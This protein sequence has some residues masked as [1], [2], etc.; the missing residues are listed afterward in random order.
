MSNTTPTNLPPIGVHSN[1]CA[2][3][4]DHA[5]DCDCALAPLYLKAKID[6]LT[7]KA[8]GLAIQV[9]ASAAK[10]ERLQ[11]AVD[12]PIPMILTCPACGARHIDVG[13]FATRRH[14]THACQDCGMVWRPAIVATC[15]VQFLPGFKNDP[16]AA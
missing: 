2:K 15:G 11:T 1:T 3:A 10:L 7:E 14:H 4:H 5:K 13:E 16:G 8:D 9:S 12:A 6:A